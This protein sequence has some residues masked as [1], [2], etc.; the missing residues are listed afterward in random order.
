MTWLLQHFQGHLA[1]GYTDENVQQ[2]ARGYI[3]QLIGGVLMPN[4]SRSQVHLAY[5]TLLEDLTVVQSWGSA[6]LSN[7]YHYLCHGCQIGKENMSGA[8][9]LLQLWAWERFP[10]VA[11]A[12]LGMRQRPPGDLETIQRGVNC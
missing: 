11:P 10:F 4:H 6:C 7:L 9:I 5:L 1:T 12:R 3:L 8:F 2:P